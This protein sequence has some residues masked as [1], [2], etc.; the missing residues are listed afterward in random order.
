MKYYIAIDNCCGWPNLVKLTDNSIISSV[1]N[2]PCHGEAEGEVECFIS[3][4]FGESWQY[5]GTPAFHES[6]K[7][8][9]NVACGLTSSN[10]F[11]AIVS[12][13]DRRGKLGEVHPPYEECSRL[14]AVVC[15]SADKAKSFVNSP[16]EYKIP[17]DEYPLVPY[18]KIVK[19]GSRL[20]CACYTSWPDK[21][22]SYIIFSEDD[23]KSWTSHAVIALN[24]YHETAL[25]FADDKNGIALCR[26]DPENRLDQFITSDGGKS[27]SFDKT[28]SGAGMS[29]GH[30]V[31]LSDGTLLM[32]YG[33]RN[34]NNWGVGLRKSNDCGKSWSRPAQL[35]HFGERTDGGYAQTIELENKQLLT[36]YYV[37]GVPFHD[38]YFV[39]QVLWTL[40]E[41]F[42][43]D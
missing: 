25:Y 12:G 40:P 41:L 42:T 37:K 39:G 31:C 32:S 22:S 4:D 9:M 10:D 24:N 43:Y 14:K 27:W 1:F 38:R 5:Q 28:V 11:L 23:G 18:G 8:R 26:Q 7:N 36:H 29:P 16:F 33:I 6:G 15:R 13:W 30:L 21:T 34:H 2:Q 20:G 3:T 17:G 19:I 35:C